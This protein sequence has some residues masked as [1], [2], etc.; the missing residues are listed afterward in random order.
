MKRNLS[1]LYFL[2]MA[3]L[4]IMGCSIKEDRDVCPC[5][6]EIEMGL[7]DSVKFENVSLE[8]QSG[9]GFHEE[10]DVDRASCG[11]SVVVQVP[12]SGVSVAAYAVPGGRLQAFGGVV[13]PE[14]ESC[15]PVYMFN[16]YVE[17]A[18]DYRV[19][20]VRLHKNYSLISV[21]MENDSGNLPF[22]V[23]V[24]G[25]VCGYTGEGELLPGRFAVMNELT[26]DGMCY[27]SVPRQND[28]SLVLSLVDDDGTVRDFALG[29]YIASSGFDWTAPDLEDIE[30]TI[31]FALSQLTVEVNE[32]EIKNVFSVTI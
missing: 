26:D 15:P 5:W 9:Q 24:T 6:L 21:Y 17:T 18:G 28:P 3:G 4:S 29:H 2:I 30:V 19:D 14:G 20:T 1:G 22:S 23:E 10:L 8:L 7:V 25:N 11:G 16:D 13:I 32:W 31:N 27:I 12:R